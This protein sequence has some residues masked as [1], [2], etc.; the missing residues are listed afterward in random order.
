[1]IVTI[2]AAYGA[3][4]SALGRRVA[5]RLGLELI[6]QTVPS[7]V[8]QK[9]GISGPDAD[10]LLRFT[11]RGFWKILTYPFSLATSAPIALRNQQQLPASD[12]DVVRAIETELFDA[13]DRGD[14][15]IV[16]HAAAMVLAG[17][18]DAVH[19]RLDGAPDGRVELAMRQHGI[20]AVAAGTQMRRSDR[21][22]S[23]YVK[24]FY[25][26]DVSDARFYDLVL[27]TVDTDWDR[28]EQLILEVAQRVSARGEYGL[29]S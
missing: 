18:P 15:V 25:Q 24:H 11:P 6:D 21:Q 28:A 7:A 20:T 3:G 10:I 14:A 16:G 17:R 23:G 22:R 12:R 9:L 13:A 4:G 29:R 1:M 5:E 19:V 27:D 2:S 8:T 26:A